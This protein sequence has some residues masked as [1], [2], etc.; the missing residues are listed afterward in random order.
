[1]RR[2]KERSGREKRIRTKKM[3]RTRR[4]NKGATSEGEEKPREMI[5]V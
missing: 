3:K 1:M 4:I 5:N 2:E